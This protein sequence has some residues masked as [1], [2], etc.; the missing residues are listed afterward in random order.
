MAGRREKGGDGAEASA[1]NFFERE[2]ER[3][4]K[5]EKM[6]RMKRESHLHAN[7]VPS[8]ST[9]LLGTLPATLE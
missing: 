4:R 5:E 9:A 8:P 2:I 1:A 7:A 3:G 6:R